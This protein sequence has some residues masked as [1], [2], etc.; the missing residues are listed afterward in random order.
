MSLIQE[1][2]R[3]R[4]EDGEGPPFLRVAGTPPPVPT[5]PPPRRKQTS[6]ILVMVALVLLVLTLLAALGGVALYFYRSLPREP[7][8]VASATGPAAPAVETTP[9]AGPVDRVPEAAP[10]AAPSP[11][12]KVAPAQAAVPAETPPPRAAP[13]APA[14][15]GEVV[16]QPVAPAAPASSD[17]LVGAH[18]QQAESEARSAAE[19]AARAVIPTNIVAS[20]PV[21]ER[22]KRAFSR[23]PSPPSWPGLRVTGVMAGGGPRA[24]TAFVDGNLVE[25]GDEISGVRVLGVSQA[26]VLFKF[27]NQTQF[28]RVGQTTTQ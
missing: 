10:S 9:P 5:G 14:G 19:E 28:V 2:L 22:W 8:Q 27:Q 21:P 12:R 4:E 1:A 24:A 20:L 26:G 15:R 6:D 18:Q 25:V 3:R 16:P 23:K 17:P 13:A 7:A 11:P